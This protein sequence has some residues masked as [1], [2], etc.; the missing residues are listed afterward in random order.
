M[1]LRCDFE[2]LRALKEGARMVLEDE[3]GAGASVAAPPE[4]RAEVERLLPRLDGDLTVETLA[5]QR[6]VARALETIVGALRAEMEAAVV[7]HHPAEDAAVEAYFAFS[8]ALTVLNRAEE[9]GQEMEALIEVVT[10]EEPDEEVA[11]TF[12]FPD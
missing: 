2:E 10:G 1:I 11:R 9:I 6:A 8:H 12:E 4:G 3:G 5:E 7:A